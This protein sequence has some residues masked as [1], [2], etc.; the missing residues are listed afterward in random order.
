M[1]AN[2]KNIKSVQKVNKPLLQTESAGVRLLKKIDAEK[3][4]VAVIVSFV[5][6]SSYDHLFTSV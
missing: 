3:K 6:G 2:Q 1:R 4:V 5:N